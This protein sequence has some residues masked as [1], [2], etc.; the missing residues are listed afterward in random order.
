M[1]FAA[2]AG[3]IKPSL[4]V[5]CVHYTFLTKFELLLP[6]LLF[7]VFLL[8]QSLIQCPVVIHLLWT[9]CKVVSQVIEFIYFRPL[10]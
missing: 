10:A 1:Q 2:H 8:F 3:T 6:L 7:F 9:L 4:Y 5:I